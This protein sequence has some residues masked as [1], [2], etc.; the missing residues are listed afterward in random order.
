MTRSAEGTRNRFESMSIPGL[1][2]RAQDAV[3]AAL[4]AM[5]DWRSEAA[6]SSEKNIK[7]VI[8]KMATAA[9][10]LGWPEQIVDTARTQL[11]NLAEMQIKKMDQTVDAWEEQLKLPNP[12]SPT[13]MLSKLKSSTGTPGSSR[14]ADAFQ[15]GVTSPLQFWMSFAGQWQKAWTDMMTTWTRAGKSSDREGGHRH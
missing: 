12:A 6:E 9:E 5:S 15:M 8:N 1:S 4:E 7:R 11:Q 14:G 3:N 10:E 2:S 13:A